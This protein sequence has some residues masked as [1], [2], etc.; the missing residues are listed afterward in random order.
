MRGCDRKWKQKW[1]CPKNGDL[2]VFPPS[3]LSATHRSS[4]SSMSDHS[5][6]AVTQ[7]PPFFCYTIRGTRC[8]ATG[9]YILVSSSCLRHMV[10]GDTILRRHTRR[11]VFRSTGCRTGG[12]AIFRRLIFPYL[13][14]YVG[15]DVVCMWKSVLDLTSEN[16]NSIQKIIGERTHRCRALGTNVTVSEVTGSIPQATNELFSRGWRQVSDTS[17]P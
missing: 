11:S 8:F 7:R 3:P 14:N 1:K 6:R 13:F 2:F 12:R 15:Y 16:F 5:W 4:S 17:R 10:A 9:Y